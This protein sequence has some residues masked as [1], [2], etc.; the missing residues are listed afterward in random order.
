[1]T[2]VRLR[3]LRDADTDLLVQ[4]RIDHAEAMGYPGGAPDQREI[5]ARLTERIAHS[6]EFFRGE[7][8]YGVVA[9]GRLVGEVQARRPEHAMPA[10]VFELGIGL[11][12]QA[13][14]G[15]G[16]GTKA[17]A[18]MTRKVMDEDG[19]HRVQAGTDVDNAPMRGVL[20]KLGFECEGIMKG[21]MPSPTGPRDY[22]LYGITAERYRK[23]SD[24]WI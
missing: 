9:D 5:R 3:R 12:D 13:D 8:L 7:Y 10:G 15:H 16:V 6:G 20:D 11:F 24:G 17:I 21:F 23:V 19:A 1:V 22:A 2:D 18:L 4:A 14:R